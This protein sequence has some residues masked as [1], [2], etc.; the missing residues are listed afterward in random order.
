M[1]RAKVI[2]QCWSGQVDWHLAISLRQ[3][4]L[5]KILPGKASTLDLVDLFCSILY[6]LP[7]IFLGINFNGGGGIVNS[8]RDQLLLCIGRFLPRCK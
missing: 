5:S 1:A 2:V 7:P 6:G 4:I 8:I 3:V